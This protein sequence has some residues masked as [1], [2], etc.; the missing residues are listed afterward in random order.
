MLK[1]WLELLNDLQIKPF[2]LIIVR[3]PL[4][5]AYSLQSANGLPLEQ[6][7]LLWLRHVLEAEYNSR[8]LSR[9]VVMFSGLQNDWKANLQRVALQTG[10]EWPCLSC[11]TEIEINKFLTKE[12]HRARASDDELR[13]NPSISAWATSTYGLMGK[14]VDDPHNLG[15]LGAL[16]DLRHSFEVACTTFG[17][18]LSAQERLMESVKSDLTTRIVG[19]NSEIATLSDATNAKAAAQQVALDQDD[20]PHRDLEAQLDVVQANITRRLE[21]ATRTLPLSGPRL[22]RAHAR[23][24]DLEIQLETRA[25]RNH[26]SGGDRGGGSRASGGDGQHQHCAA[27]GTAEREQRTSRCGPVSE[28]LRLN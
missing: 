17:T 23:V 8:D 11:T 21:I 5:V 15:V 3:N 10:L 14:L 13:S 19:L 7:M 12:L 25:G 9:S 28:A 2:A 1:F 26:L 27:G 4:E 6:S 20:G 22:E 24:A 16:D 18:V